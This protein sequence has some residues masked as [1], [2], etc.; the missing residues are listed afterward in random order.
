[1][2]GRETNTNLLEYLEFLT[3]MLDQRKAVH[4]LYLDFAKAFDKVPHKRLFEK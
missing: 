1:M 4:V 3:K 2:A